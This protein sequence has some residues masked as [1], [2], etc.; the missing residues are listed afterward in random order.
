MR[1][2]TQPLGTSNISGNMIEK[3]RRQR[4][5]K[6]KYVVDKLDI[7]GIKMTVSSLSKIEG[8][9]RQVAD[10]ELLAIADILEV[11]VTELLKD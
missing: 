1:V 6:Q 9:I 4:G 7:R 10:Y 8:Q 5:F 2:R 3:I 11:P